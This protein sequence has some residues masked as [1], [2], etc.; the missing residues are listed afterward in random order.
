M[1]IGIVSDTHRLNGYIKKAC[2]YLKD[3]DLV[4]HLGDNIE[5]A[6]KI[7]QY[8]KGKVI[9]VRGNCDFTKDVPSERIEIIENKKFFITHGHNYNV[10]SNMINLKYKA[11]E[12]GADIALFG[13]T[14]IA[15]IV[16]DD[17]ILFINP[18]SV[19]MPRS[20]KNSIAFIEIIDGNIHANIKTL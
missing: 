20:G 4:I 5:D 2:E 3:C 16:E 6:A 7:K 15:E 19:S 14:H 9:N 11:L 18:G 17:G 13:H 10:K 1:L 12:I 8:Y